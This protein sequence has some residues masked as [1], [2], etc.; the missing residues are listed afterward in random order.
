[1][2]GRP[3]FFLLIHIDNELFNEPVGLYLLAMKKILS[4]AV[5]LF[6]L[7]SI[8]V[9]SAEIVCGP[10]G[11]ERGQVCFDALNPGDLLHFTCTETDYGSSGQISGD[12]QIG[13]YLQEGYFNVAGGSAVLSSSPLVNGASSAIQIQSADDTGPFVNLESAT[14]FGSSPQYPQMEFRLNF[15]GKPSEV[16]LD[17]VNQGAILV[18]NCTATH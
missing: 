6:F 7:F 13:T 17:P 1:V 4:V 8:S 11:N 10:S 2:A 18:L 9:A 3:K 15:K 5:L 16:L 14:F 12:I